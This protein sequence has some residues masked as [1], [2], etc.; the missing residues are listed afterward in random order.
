MGPILKVLGVVMVVVAMGIFYREATGQEAVNPDGIMELSQTEWR[1]KL[2]PLQYRVLWE[3][4][5]E[6]PFS[7]EL[8]HNKEKG[9][10][11]SAGCG[12]PVFHSNHK[13]DSK[14]GW[15][16]FWKPID[17]G[18][19]TIQADDHLGTRRWEVV[20]SQCGE[21]LGHVFEDGPEPTGKRYC[22]NSAALKF[23]PDRE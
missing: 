14:T 18:A 8:L 19:V 23:I 12:Q 1:E 16:S 4:G 7:G 9:V 10:Y 11:V 6:R 22:I 20:S 21:H 3:K 15:P 5:T 13:Y 17:E 2:T